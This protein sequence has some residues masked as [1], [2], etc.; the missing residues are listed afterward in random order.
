[1]ITKIFNLIL[2]S[3]V[4]L[5][6]ACSSNSQSEETQE[7]EISGNDKL[8]PIGEFEEFNVVDEWNE[9]PFDWFK[10]Q[11]LLLAV[12]TP[13][14]NNAMT[15][16]WGSLGNIW[17]KIGPATV[18]VYVAEGRYTYEFMEKYDYFTV[19][20][21]GKEDARILGYMGTHSGRDGDKA[22]HLGLHTLY[23][24]NGTPYYAEATMV[25]ECKTIYKAPF[26]KE[27]MCEEVRKFYENFDA[28][29]H[30]MYIGNVVKALKRKT[31]EE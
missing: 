5:M 8:A 23:T 9:N 24:E 6:V 25:L 22:A 21:F 31:V 26:L 29:V 1:M 12:G 20:A 10:G 11:G 7:Q 28:S 17:S 2:L 27:G 19:M 15:I 30:H 3:S 4:C 13:E 16:G 18:T 14:H